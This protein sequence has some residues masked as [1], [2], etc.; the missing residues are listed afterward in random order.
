MTR[1]ADHRT[2]VTI[3]WLRRRLTPKSLRSGLSLAALAVTAVWVILLTAA[4]NLILANRLG[5]QADD[6]LRTRTGAVAALVQVDATGQV[7]LRAPADGSGIDRGVWVFA[8]DRVLHRPADEDE[9]DDAAASLARTGGFASPDDDPLTRLYAQPVR[10]DGTQVATV[11]AAI[12]LDASLDARRVT[13]IGSAIVAGILL[14]LVYLTSRAMVARTLQPVE[15]MARQAAEW[16]AT[17][18]EHRFGDQRRPAELDRLATILD[19][20][21]ARQAAVV[22]SDQ[23]LTAE[24]SHELRTPLAAMSAELDLLRSRPR[25]P[26]ELEAGHASL[27]AGISRLGGLIE[28]LLTEARGRARSV[29]GRSTL[30]PVL[31][32]LA[33]TARGHDVRLVVRPEP[34]PALTAGVDADVLDRILSP[35]IDNARRFARST[36]TLTAER[37]ATSVTVTVSDDGPGVPPELADRVFE[38]GFSEGGH[39]GAGLGLPLARRLARGANGDV[40]LDPGGAAFVVLLPPG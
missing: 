1:A 22:R 16:S 11:V 12:D 25:S 38:P 18:L 21:L 13:L 5:S 4:F 6:T 17:D 35:L 15:Q 27:A 31:H 28:T 24:L 29:P 34:D 39:G 19:E 32:G 2:M 26:T 9:L 36:V 40:V 33:D 20:L 14:L 37:T 10:I 30:G 3:A 8:G 23:Q 7:S